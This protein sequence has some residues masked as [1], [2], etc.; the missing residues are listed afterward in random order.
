MYP[1]LIEYVPFIK[2]V[3]RAP[4]RITIIHYLLRLLSNCNFMDETAQSYLRVCLVLLPYYIEKGWSQ[5][6]NS[7]LFVE[8]LTAK[9]RSGCSWRWSS[10][11]RST[12]EEDIEVF[13]P[14]TY[15]MILRTSFF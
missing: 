10:G 8:L 7:Q 9:N 5:S 3:P 12:L 1:V 6:M 15:L 14:K 2:H 13:S 4:A 11:T